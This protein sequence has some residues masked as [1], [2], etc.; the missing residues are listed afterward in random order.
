MGYDWNSEYWGRHLSQPERNDL[1]DDMWIKRHESV[2]KGLS[3][4]ALDL[5]CGIGQNSDYLS[6]L[7][8]SVIGADLS[9]VALSELRRRNPKVETV[10]LDMTS[11]LPFDDKSFDIVVASL[12][13]H[14]FSRKDT[15]SLCAEI[16][17]V[18]VDGGIFIGA[19][20]SSLAY[21]YIADHAITLEDNF[22]LSG[23]RFIRLFDRAQFDEFFCDY[24]RILLELTHSV[25]FGEPKDMW[26]FIFRKPIS[27]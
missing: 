18:L 7:G 8:F 4:R 5:G 19:V 10:A 2:L 12:S 13:I 25:R 21:K 27:N 24:E 3:G 20:N 11:P 6:E 23:N 15:R 14:Y 1:F 26:E 9:T 16:L 22:Y 17:R